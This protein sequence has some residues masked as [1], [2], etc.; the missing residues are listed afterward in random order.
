[1]NE[2][3]DNELEALIAANLL[4]VDGGQCAFESWADI[5]PELVKFARDVLAKWGTPA[6]VGVEPAPSADGPKELWLQLHGDC[7]PHE[8][9]EPV[10]YTSDDVTWCWHSIHDSDVR[11]VRADLAADQALAMGR[12]PQVDAA[13]KALAECMDYPWEHMPEAGR[14]AMREHAQKVLSAAHGIKQGGQHDI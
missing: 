14:Q 1:M 13:A 4:V 5:R 8:Q 12:V 10:D 7:L 11:Y 6:P 3:T 2:P 9:S